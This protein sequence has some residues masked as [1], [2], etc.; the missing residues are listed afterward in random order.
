V[1]GATIPLPRPAGLLLEKLLTD[2]S[3]EKG[4]RDLLVVLGMLIVVDAEAIAELVEACTRVPE[5]LR[6][7]ILSNLTILSLLFLASRSP[8]RRELLARL[9]APFRV[10]CAEIDE[11]PLAREPP[12][13]LAA[14]LA[15]AKARAGAANQPA[16]PDGP[17]AAA[18]VVLGADTLVVTGSA[19]LGKPRDRE[20]ALAQLAALSG[21]EHAVLTAVAVWADGPGGAPRIEAR[22]IRTR[23]WMRVIPPAERDA[24]W[25]TGEP[26]DKAGSYAIQGIGARF[27]TRIEGSYSAV[28]GLPLHETASLLGRAGV[29]LGLEPAPAP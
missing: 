27:V 16:P 11:T 29:A 19:V 15:L 22:L 25:R 6:H 20:A 12:D 28:V 3:G 8:R 18:R 1:D 17:G 23:V 4:D 2:R 24:Y 21:R 14:R 5:D 7:A 13:L 9:G 26:A 10:V